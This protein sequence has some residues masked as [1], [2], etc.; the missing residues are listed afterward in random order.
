MK[1]E[2]LFIELLQVSLGNRKEL[3]V[4]PT[5]DEWLALYKISKQQS[6]VGLCFYGMKQLSAE[7][8]PPLLILRQWTVK[9][10]KLEEKNRNLNEECK[11]AT[12]VFT[13]GS[14][15]TC[16]LKGQGNLY[17]YPAHLK[18]LRSPG[19]IDLWVWQKERK[20]LD[21]PRLI[22]GIRKISG[23][24]VDIGIHHA[25]CNM[26]AD[27]LL[28]V[29]FQPSFSINPFTDAKMKKWW[30]E[31]RDYR[32][33][34][35]KGFYYP[36]KDFNLVF[37]MS[38]IYRHILLEG[39]GFRQLLDYYFVLISDGSATN[40]NAVMGDICHLN[41]KHITQA[42]MWIMTT[43]FTMDTK[44]LLCEPSER[45][46]MKLLHEILA[47]G[48]FGHYLE[49]RFE[50]ENDDDGKETIKSK[51]KGNFEV[52][53]RGWKWLLYYPSEAIW[54]PYLCIRASFTR[55]KM[56]RIE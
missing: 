42:V 6:I 45:Y 44:Y 34:S 53:K 54:T 56:R 7:C 51:F 26:F 27:N 38:H 47:G 9:A 23:G 13:N 48:N 46:G 20:E 43:V 50:A 21:M 17:Y 24:Q 36:N 29:H 15:E 12:N 16:V 2:S 10:L 22:K 41:M 18:T 8:Q 4:I 14:Y 11:F 32:L 31:H 25:E 55:N 1:I 35:D 19:D 3:S 5:E 49:G 28:E 37:Q 40:K 30:I 39:I 33:I 52:I